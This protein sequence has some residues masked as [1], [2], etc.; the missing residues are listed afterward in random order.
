MTSISCF[1]LQPPSY[2]QV[3]LST[4]SHLNIYIYNLGSLVSAAHICVG[5]GH[6]PVPT[7]SN[8]NDVSFPSTHQLPRA[9]QQGMGLGDHI[10]HLCITW[11]G[12]L[13]PTAAVSLQVGQPCHVQKAAHHSTPPHPPAPTFSPLLHTVLPEH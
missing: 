3:T 4:L 2:Q 1:N 9:P 8:D 12:W 7:S 6:P 13:D 5:V 10:P 11:I